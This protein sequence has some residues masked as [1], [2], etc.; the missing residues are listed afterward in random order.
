MDFPVIQKFLLASYHDL[1]NILFMGSL[2]LGSLLGYLPLIWLAF[3]MVFNGAAT[4]LMQLVLQNMR[5]WGWLNWLGPLKDQI[6][7]SGADYAKCFVGFQKD[8]NGTFN[9]LTGSS[10]PV[11]APSYWMSSSTFFTVFS[12]YNSI[13][14]VARE[15]K[16][17]DPILVSTRRAFSISTLII[18]LFFL[19]LVFARAF[20]GCETLLGGTLGVLLGAGIAVAYWHILDSCGTGKIPDVLQV[21]GSIA[22]EKNKAKQPVMCT[23]TE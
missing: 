17:V 14:V 2:I 9:S 15:S 5:K 1:P 20:T 18:G 11:V 22:P 10:T 8:V 6:E 3:G 12:I 16:N 21:V 13:R 23:A 4:G 19:F 7:V